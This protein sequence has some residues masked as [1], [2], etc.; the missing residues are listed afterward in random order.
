[1]TTPLRTQALLV[2]A[3][4]TVYTGTSFGATG[5]ALGEAVFTTGMTGYQETLT[6]PSFH[7]Q[8]VCMTAPQI[9]NTGWNDEDGESVLD[10]ANPTADTGGKIW[11]AGFIIRDLTRSTS[12]FRATRGLEEELINQGVIGIARIDTRALV[13]HLRNHG[14]IAA[15]IFSGDDA[16]KPREELLEIVRTQPSMAGARLA[17]EVSTTESYLV[18]AEGEK[19]ASIAAVDLGIKSNTPR[20]LARRGVDVHVVPSTVTFEEIQA[21]DVDGVFVSNGPGDPATMD[22]LV[23]LTQTVLRHDIPFF[24]ICFG[25]QILGRA[26]G[27]KTEKMVFGHRGINVPVTDL[28]TGTVAIT[29]QNHGF[30]L[31]SDNREFDTEFGPAE[32]THICSNDD[33]VEGVALS[34]GRA[35]SVQY[36][37][38]SAAGPH[39]AHTLF[40]DFVTLLTGKAGA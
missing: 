12:N 22:D 16:T 10:P 21:L 4:G 23:E 38:E 28:K 13:R 27:L 14:S 34:S 20:L 8:L 7:R 5:T 36:H 11:V 1:M 31:V 26:L 29:S 17:D 37:P 18:P 40:D 24:G 6:D 15:G 19:V 9:G 32:V 2:L 35:F 3:D 33:T 30:M 25:N 39:D